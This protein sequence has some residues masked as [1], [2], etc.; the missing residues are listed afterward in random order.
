MLHPVDV[1]SFQP[2]AHSPGLP[3]R[4]EGTERLP[5]AALLSVGAAAGLCSGDA[6]L[7]SVPGL[8][9]G[10]C[11]CCTWDLALGPRPWPGPQSPSEA[12]RPR[13]APAAR[14]CPC[15]T[16]PAVPARSQDLP[17]HCRL[18]GLGESHPGTSQMSF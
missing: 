9:G 6:T 11:G 5:V 14:G 18:R 2:R 1:G 3:P 16:T 10:A 12:S 15:G 8:P 13:R 17:A 7:P 4:A